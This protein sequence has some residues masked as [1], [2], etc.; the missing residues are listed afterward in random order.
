MGIWNSFSIYP[1]YLLSKK[2]TFAT[3]LIT[4]VQLNYVNTW[5]FWSFWSIIELKKM[6][7]SIL[8]IKFILSLYLEA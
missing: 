3:D 1:N 4:V 6:P 7:F 8:R 5:H 2:V